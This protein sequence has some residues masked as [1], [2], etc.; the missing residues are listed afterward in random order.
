M[1]LF[2]GTTVTASIF[3]ISLLSVDR[4]MAIKKP[5]ISRRIGSPRVAAKLILF[6]WTAAALPM[7]PLF[8]FR[9]VDEISFLSES[10]VHFCREDW[11]SPMDRLIYDISVCVVVYL[12]PG[13]TIATSYVLIGRKLWY[14]DENLQRQ[15]SE[16]SRRISRQVMNSRKRIAKMLI[17]LAV[18]FAACWLPYHITCLQIDVTHVLSGFRGSGV[19]HA[20]TALP[21][22]I[23]LGHANSAINPLIYFYASRSFRRCVVKVV[24]CKRRADGEDDQVS[25][26]LS[27]YV[28]L[29]ACLLTPGFEGWGR[30]HSIQL[31]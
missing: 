19:T 15:E 7:I 2:A 16:I 25:K 11:L 12:I 4:Y 3:T 13:A 5:V 10:S 14:E 18:L 28:I 31:T 29:H 22:T 1:L 27:N 24:R 9:K 17:V 30:T 8:L 6:V 21:Y 20:M 26:G 23:L